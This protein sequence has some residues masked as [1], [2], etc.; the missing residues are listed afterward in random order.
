[1]LIDNILEYNILL[2]E[3]ENDSSILL[4]NDIIISDNKIGVRG[5]VGTIASSDVKNKNSSYILNKCLEL[6][7]LACDED[8]NLDYA[9][10]HE[11]DM[12]VDYI[13]K[14]LDIDLNFDFSKYKKRL[15]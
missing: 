7:K 13:L 10:F 5:K 11:G 9:I 15:Q 12:E 8:Y 14:D 6:L 4:K 2:S 3:L 1:M